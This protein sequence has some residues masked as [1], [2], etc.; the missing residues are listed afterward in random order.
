ML[1]GKRVQGIVNNLLFLSSTIML[2]LKSLKI[3]V[4]N[5]CQVEVEVEV[6]AVGVVP[7]PPE[8]LPPHRLTVWMMR[9]TR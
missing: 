9:Y 5:R 6:D 4:S 7:P 2:V 1:L 3:C 8:R